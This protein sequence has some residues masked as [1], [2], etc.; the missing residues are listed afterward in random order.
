MSFFSCYK[1]L[2]RRKKS[3]QEKI[4]TSLNLSLNNF[5]FCNL[6]LI[7]KPNNDVSYLKYIYVTIKIISVKF[8]KLLLMK[9]PLIKIQIYSC[10]VSKSTIINIVNSKTL[11]C[12]VFCTQQ[13]VYIRT[14]YMLQYTTYYIQICFRAKAVFNLYVK[15]FFSS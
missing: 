2:L 3:L 1:I 14:T 4:F 12:T 8:S 7:I 9:I 10:V 11:N 5:M 6:F 13:S 15:I